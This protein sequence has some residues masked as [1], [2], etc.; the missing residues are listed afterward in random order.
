MKS[1][2]SFCLRNSDYLVDTRLALQTVVA[3]LAFDFEDAKLEVSSAATLTLV[4]GFLNMPPILHAVVFV[5]LEHLP[6]KQLAFHA[7]DS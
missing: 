2:F 5:H 6:R 7:T 1:A 4:L 3:L